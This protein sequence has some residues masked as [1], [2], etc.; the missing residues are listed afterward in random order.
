MDAVIYFAE[1]EEI[2]QRMH[3]ILSNPFIK[4]PQEALQSLQLEQKQLETRYM[5][6]EP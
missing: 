3:A 5:M 4:D 2:T 1:L 6:M